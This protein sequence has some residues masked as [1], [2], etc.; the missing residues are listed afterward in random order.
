[1]LRFEFAISHL[2]D[3]R[4]GVAQSFS[5]EIGKEVADWPDE[6]AALAGRV[7]EFSLTQRR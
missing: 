6:G 7:R 1:M 5:L 4:C 2:C 3:E